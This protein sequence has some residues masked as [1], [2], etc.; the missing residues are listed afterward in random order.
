MT[1]SAQ[2]M[3]DLYIQAEKDVL[4]GK[5]TSINGRVF[6]SENLIDIRNGRKEWERRVLNETAA[7]TG[8]RRKRSS[9]ASF[10]E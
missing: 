8:K 7:A 6:T 10:Y 5:S 3:V 4:D 2:E 9:L 1:Q